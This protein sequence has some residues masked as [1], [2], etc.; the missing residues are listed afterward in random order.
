VDLDEAK[1]RVA[2]GIEDESRRARVEQA[3]A[4]ISIPR[5]AVMIE[6]MGQIRPL[7]RSQPK[8]RSTTHVRP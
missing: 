6:V 4:S 1:N 5:A 2:I 3:L 7:H 8:K